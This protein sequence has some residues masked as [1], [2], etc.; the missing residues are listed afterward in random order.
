MTRTRRIG[1]GLLSR[2]EQTGSDR[3]RWAEEQGFDSVWVPDGDGKM[4][5]LTLSGAVAATTS[6]ITVAT[7]IVP[8]YTHTPAVLAAS[9]M[10]L[11]HLAPGRFVLGLGSSS[12][13]MMESWNGIPFVKPLTRVRET[14]QVLRAMLAGERVDFQGQTLSSKGFR[15][16]PLPPTPVPIYLA[17][18]RPNMLELA[19]EV[20]DGVIL[21]LVP[22]RALPGM[23]EHIA[24]GARRAGRSLADLDIVCRFNGVVTD[25]RAAGLNDV[26]SFIAR[27]F[28]APVY[29][30]YFAACG[31]E[32]EAK[33]FADGFARGDRAA[34]AAAITDQVVSEVGMVGTEAECQAQVRAFYD[35]GVNTVSIIPLCQT[36]EDTDRTFLTFAPKHFKP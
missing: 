12:K 9:A 2:A 6:R 34:T 1:V 21:N 14:V 17:A 19:G 26:R 20:A 29:N 13:A 27:Y 5:A 22:L 35:A 31:F 4:H 25:D 32:A 30:K 11:A 18:L 7:S 3:A 24:A 16:N 8:V 15:L 23:L 28:A 10:T 33:A 36:V